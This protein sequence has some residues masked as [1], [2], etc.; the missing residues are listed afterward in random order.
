MDK[1]KLNQKDFYKKLKNSKIKNDIH[2]TSDISINPLYT[3]LDISELDYHKDLN[4]P[5]EYPYT[6]GIHPSM[7]RGKLWT[8]RQYAG[9]GDAT[10]TNKRFHYLLKN[11]NQ[12]MYSF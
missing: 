2:T 10:E 9:Y 5:G 7:Y 3:P 12:Y 8:M 1:I 6:R 4:F 11:K